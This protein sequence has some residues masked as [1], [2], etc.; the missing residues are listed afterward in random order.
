[1]ILLKSY[2]KSGNTWLRFI[3]C[4]LLYPDVEHDFSTIKKYCPT[5]EDKD[6]NYDWGFKPKLAK[7]HDINEVIPGNIIY[8]HRH[9]GDVLI[10]FWWH[11]KKFFDE[12]RTLEQFC[13]GLNFGEGWREF[14]NVSSLNCIMYEEMDDVE[15]L[16]NAT[17]LDYSDDEW[18]IAINKSTF[19]KLRKIEINK[20]L[21]I[22][23]DKSIYFIR[24]GYIENGQFYDKK[25]ADKILET[26]KRELKL[27]GYVN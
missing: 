3:L 17:N 18:E 25:I 1:M 5:L 4:N 27:L 26:N 8:I 12:Q 24:S 16:K 22:E 11:C 2:P 19:D 7:T 21:D 15:R 6:E 9:V 13:E 14:V 23:S 20:G 10:S